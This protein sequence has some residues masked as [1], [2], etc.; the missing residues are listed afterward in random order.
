MSS[1]FGMVLYGIGAWL[2]LSVIFAAILCR[3]IN[4]AKQREK[5]FQGRTGSMEA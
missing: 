1:A 4:A 2:V 5:Q 3:C